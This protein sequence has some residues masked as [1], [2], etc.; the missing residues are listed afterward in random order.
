MGFMAS[1]TLLSAI[2]LKLFTVLGK[3]T[4]TAEQIGDRLALHPRGLYDFLDALVALGFLARE[5]DGPG[6]HYGNTFDGGIFLDEMSPFHL[7]GILEMANA[8]L[9][10]FWGHLTEALRTGEPQNE[11][12]QGKGSPFDIIYADEARLEQFLRAMQGIQLGNF[13]VLTEKI[14]FGK[15]ERFC[16]VGGANG[17]LASL[18]SKR[19]PKLSC[20]TFDLPVVAPIAKR[21]TTAMEAPNVEVLAGDF[22][23]DALPSADVITMGNILHDW[24]EDEKRML[25]RKAYEAVRP[26]GMFIAIENVIDD[27]RRANVFGLLMSLN[28][29]IELP[30]GFDYTGAQFDGWAREAGFERTE[31]V[32]LAGPTSAAIAYKPKG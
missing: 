17:T 24:N 28:M 18:V 4:M 29:L 22:F 1:K 19:Y 31:I 9:Y 32:P 7:T 15:F 13:A 26:G 21:H 10:P 11:L 27:A 20:A 25:L 14:D 8:R 2:E 6:S 16:D 5:G 30:G 23:R 3:S 12:K